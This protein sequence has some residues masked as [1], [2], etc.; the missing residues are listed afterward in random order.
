MRMPSLLWLAAALVAATAA[1]V[2]A[3]QAEKRVFI[4]V[5]NAD[6]YGID[7]CLASGASCGKAVAAAYCRAQDF[8]EALTFRRIDRAEFTGTILTEAPTCR[9]LCEDLIAIECGR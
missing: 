1:V 6:G 2:P 4:V 3:A 8:A 5:N 7:R 9:G